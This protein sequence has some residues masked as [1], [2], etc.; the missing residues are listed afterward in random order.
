M[1]ALEGSGWQHDTVV[2]QWW[3]VNDLPSLMAEIVETGSCIA[4]TEDGKTIYL[5][6]LA[7]Q[8]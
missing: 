1:Q 2:S 6:S 5:V 3:I 8:P 4:T 7:L